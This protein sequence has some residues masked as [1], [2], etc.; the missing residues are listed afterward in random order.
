[1]LKTNPPALEVAYGAVTG[2]ERAMPLPLV[3]TRDVKFEP[4]APRWARRD[5]EWP[6]LELLGS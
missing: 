5:F 1:M 2:G 3:C 4:T 6:E